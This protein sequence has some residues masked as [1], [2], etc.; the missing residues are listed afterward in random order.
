MPAAADWAYNPGLLAFLVA[1]QLWCGRVE[2]MGNVRER[3][4]SIRNE[5][6]DPVVALGPSLPRLGYQQDGLGADKDSI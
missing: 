5:A 6:K 3:F 2:W 1:L 4:Y